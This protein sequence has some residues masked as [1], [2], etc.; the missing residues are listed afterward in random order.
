MLFC[1]PWNYIN[2]E[3]EGDN[4]ELL[5]LI[6]GFIIII[7]ASDVLVDAASSLAA[8]YKVPTM[9]I[10][11]TIVAFGTCAPELAI[12]F[13]SI[14]AKNGGMALANVIGSCI[15][16][17]LLILGLASFL[18]PIRIKNE[19]IKKELPILVFITLGF[20]VLVLDVMLTP[21]EINLSRVDGIVLLLLFSLFVYYI[22]SIVRKRRDEEEAAAIMKYGKLKSS[23]YLVLSILFIIFSSDLIVDNVV[24]IANAWKIDKKIITLVVI[25]IGTSLPELVMTITA[26][27]KGEFEMAVGNIIGTNIF[28]I[29]VV[30][31]LPVALYGNLEVT[32]FNYIDMI[33]VFVSSF[34]LYLFARS[35]KKLTKFEGLI[36]FILFLLYYV[37]AIFF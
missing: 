37:Y 17:I 9:L 35:E 13:Q 19:T 24:L 34:L 23:I 33:F 20:V 18:H 22:I 21:S 12:S 25:V 28:N 29:C 36:M 7:K 5:L 4:M 16:N 26:A 2:G 10:A 11:L 14:A 6:I 27:K 8:S 3:E 1:L 30:L 32:G 15:V 31:G